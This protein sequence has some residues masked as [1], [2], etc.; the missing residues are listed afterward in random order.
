VTQGTVHPRQRGGQDRVRSCQD[1]GHSDGQ[2]LVEE[3]Q[4]PLQGD[5]EALGGPWHFQGSVGQVLDSHVGQVDGD[6]EGQ[7]PGGYAVVFETNNLLLNVVSFIWCAH[8]T[9][10]ASSTR[11]KLLR[12]NSMFL[13]LCMGPD[14]S[15]ASTDQNP[16]AAAKRVVR[17]HVNV[18]YLVLPKLRVI[19]FV[20]LRFR[21]SLILRFKVLVPWQRL[22]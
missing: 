14:L 6:P 3:S 20:T 5:R 8:P 12:S 13:L 7:Q 18:P 2:D 21:L 11:A 15:Q 1:D 17:R 16:K 22:L 9:T 19:Y 4:K 10:R